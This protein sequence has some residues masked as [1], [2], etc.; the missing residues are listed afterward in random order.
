MKN[1]IAILFFLISCN[2]FATNYY[3]KSTGNDFANNGLSSGTPFK[4]IQRAADLTLPGDT[5]FLMNG[6][7]T[8]DCEG[9]VVASI[10]RSGNTNGYIV[11]TN[12]PN[13]QPIIKF[14]GWAG[15][16]IDEGAHHIEISGIRIKGNSKNISPEAALNQPGGCNDPFSSSKSIYNGNG[17]SAE[18]YGAEHSHHLRF[19]RNTI[20]EC[21]GAGI[22]VIH[23]DYVTIENNIIYNNCWTTIY[24]ASGISL[25]QLW[26]YNNNMVGYR[27]I[28]ANNICYG[29]RLYVPWIDGPCLITDGNGIIIDDAQNTQN[30]SDLGRYKGRTYIC[31]NICYKNG[32]SGIHTYLSDR[33]DIVNN[34]AYKN[35]Q[36]TE[37]DNGEIFAN[38]SRDVNVYNNIL[39]ALSGNKINSSYSNINCNYDYNLYFGGGE[40]IVGGANSITD[41]PEFVNESLNSNTADFRLNS[42][43]P[44]INNGTSIKAP[45][46]DFD[47]NVRPSQGGIDIGAFESTQQA[48]INFLAEENIVIEDISVFPNPAKDQIMVSGLNNCNEIKIFDFTGKL[49][50]IHRIVTPLTFIDVS[51]FSTGIYFLRANK[52][53]TKFFKEN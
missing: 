25:Y 34:T 27:N 31:N 14:N 23:G 53:T 47:G 42:G 2:L 20:Y 8:N 29:N 7:Y 46:N 40:I 49:I 33:V 38:N 41:D 36:S 39:Y 4:T 44:A 48:F 16:S 26:N 10:N 24:G 15:F 45:S 17:I 9:C 32:G 50:L 22:S 1:F 21:G 30:Q 28:I 12:Y 11:Y 5:V 52:T 18:S 19:L 3:V 51:G 13:H 6:T 35:S 43:S 37:V